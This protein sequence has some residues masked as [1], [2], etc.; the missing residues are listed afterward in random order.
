MRLLSGRHGDR[1]RHRGRV[2][3]CGGRDR[4]H[5]PR[6]RPVL[7]TSMEENLRCEQKAAAGPRQRSSKVPQRS[8]LAATGNARDAAGADASAEASASASPRFQSL[9]N[10]RGPW[11]SPTSTG[12]A[13]DGWRDGCSV[14]AYGSDGARGRRREPGEYL[15]VKLY[16][17]RVHVIQYM[18]CESLVCVCIFAMCVRPEVVYL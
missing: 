12:A 1:R 3:H 15:H 7:R 14:S 5:S 11:L 17:V 10:A 2:V 9:A 6:D 8:A 13:G 4:R 16:L 18:S